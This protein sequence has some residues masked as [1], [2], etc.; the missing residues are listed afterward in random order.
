MHGLDGR[1]VFDLLC[2]GDPVAVGDL[3][4]LETAVAEIAIVDHGTTLPA[5]DDVGA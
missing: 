2:V 4:D 5:V 3:R 1:V